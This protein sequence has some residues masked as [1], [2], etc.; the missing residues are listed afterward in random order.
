MAEDPVDELYALPRE[1]FVAA[2]NAL[3]ARLKREGRADEAAAVKKLVKPTVAV[4]ALNRLAREEPQLVRA[5]RKAGDE[6]RKAQTRALSR[7]SGAEALR[8]ASAA[9]HEAVRALLDAA[10]PLPASA[11]DVVRESLVAASL[12]PGA[13]AELAAGRLQSELEAP[14]FPSGLAAPAAPARKGDQLAER[15]QARAA[16][17]ERVAA[18]R[19]RIR[20]VERELEQARFELR[21]LDD[22]VDSLEA[23]LEQLQSEDGPGP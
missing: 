21:R 7:T 23:E 18:R 15:R 20:E 17:R 16:E 19:R 1:E 9:Q 13:G 3:A 5:L 22:R 8:G 4:A 14:A 12:D 2:R 11:R 6:L 10:G